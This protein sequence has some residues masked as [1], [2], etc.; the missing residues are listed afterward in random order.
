MAENMNFGV[1]RIGIILVVYVQEHCRTYGHKFIHS[2]HLL[3]TG[4]VSGTYQALG[5]EQGTSRI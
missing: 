5:I 1:I 2:T 3:H 4:D